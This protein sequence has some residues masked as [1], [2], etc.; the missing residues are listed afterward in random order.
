MCVFLLCHISKTL[1]PEF[2]FSFFLSI[3]TLLVVK[4]YLP[5]I[6]ILTTPISGD[7]TIEAYQTA[8]KGK[9]AIG[10]TSEGPV[11]GTL[12]GTMTTASSNDDPANSTTTTNTT[13]ES[14]NT[15]E[16]SN[17]TN[18]TSSPTPTASSSGAAAGFGAS[19]ALIGAL[20]VGAMAFVM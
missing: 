10:P 15:T 13:T 4:K 2:P 18:T 20:V 8:S 14:T 12:V 6:Y 19:V 3:S 5:T 11:G 7:E 17:T 1:N 9:E 16:S